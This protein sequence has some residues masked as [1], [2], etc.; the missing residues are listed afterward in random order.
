MKFLLVEDNHDLANAVCAR[1]QMDGHVV[2]H[3]DKIA[4]A[5][6]YVDTGDYDL[7]LLDIM[8]PMAMAEAF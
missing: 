6:A 5:S 1:L 3:A 2:D 4:D 7:I 8:L